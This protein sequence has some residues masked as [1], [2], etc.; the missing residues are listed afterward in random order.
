MGVRTHDIF[1]AATR[2]QSAAPGTYGGGRRA[3]TVFL[4]PRVPNVR[5]Q[6]ADVERSDAIY[7][8]VLGL[9]IVKQ[10]E[11]AGGVRRPRRWK[12]PS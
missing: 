3:G 11:G 10:S 1:G 9:R 12:G 6:I 4:R 5:L 2:A 8:D 7:Q